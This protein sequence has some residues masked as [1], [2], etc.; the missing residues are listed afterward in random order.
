MRESDTAM[1][2]FAALFS[3]LGAR[4]RRLRGALG[5][6]GQSLFEFGVLSAFALGSFGLALSHWP[7]ARAL[8]WGAVAP[9]LFVTGYALLDLRRQRADGA[10]ESARKG[11]DWVALGWT[12]CCAGLAIALFAWAMSYAPPQPAEAQGWQPPEDTVT[13]DMAP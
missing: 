10:A 6:R 8:A 5:D 11:H 9:L 4:R 12:L 7:A 2:Y 13:L 1:G 3:E